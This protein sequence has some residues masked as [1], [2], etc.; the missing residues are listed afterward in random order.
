[1]RNFE[2]SLLVEMHREPQLIVEL[3]GKAA[4]RETIS[5]TGDELLTLFP[6]YFAMLQAAAHLCPRPPMPKPFRVREDELNAFFYCS[7]FL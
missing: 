3:L 7:N 2:R 1:V 5:D 4:G 6:V